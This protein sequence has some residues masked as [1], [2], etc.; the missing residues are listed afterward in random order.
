MIHL[1]AIEMMQGGSNGPTIQLRGA[2]EKLNS[3]A[4]RYRWMREN[5]SADME[6]Y[7]FGKHGQGA[8]GMDEAIDAAIL[9][10]PNVKITGLAPGKDD[11]RKK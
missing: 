9:K 4:M 1:N 3:D 7:L 6:W 11:R 10:S 2:I 8:T 5:I